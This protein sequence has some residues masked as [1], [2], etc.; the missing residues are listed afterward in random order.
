VVQGTVSSVELNY[1]NSVTEY[2]VAV[3]A[4]YRSS[5]SE[6]LRGS[7]TTL[8]L[9]MV[10]NLELFDIT[11]STMRVRWRTA[12]GA[13]GYMILYAPLTEGDPAD[14]KELRAE[15]NENN[16]GSGW[17]SSSAED[18]PGSEALLS[19]PRARLPPARMASTRGAMWGTP[20]GQIQ[21]QIQSSL[22]ELK[23]I[24]RKAPQR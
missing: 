17:M 11:H 24:Q 19:E 1:L 10:N 7:A 6:G 15:S 8:A 16:L 20:L 22:S 21:S 5:A 18:Q 23:C 14:E 12:T 4:I 3:F 2:Q 13:S 9:P